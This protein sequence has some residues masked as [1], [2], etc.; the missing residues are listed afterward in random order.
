[1]ISES[2]RVT[3]AAEARFRIQ[4]PN[5]RPPLVKV[6]ALDT[7]AESVVR[8]LAAGGWQ[9]ATFF[10]AASAD[11]TLTDLTGGR[12]APDAEV[13]A[14]DLVILIAGPGGHAH[15]VSTIGNACSSRRVMTTGCVVSASSAS[16]RELA[17]TLAQLRPWSLMLVIAKS[18]E[19]LDDML[20]ALRA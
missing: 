19:Y 6:V 9:Q 5:S 12:R 2:A 1:M 11:G 13:E 20:T 8:R 10:V 7:I 17:K 15:G 14:A 18:D 16:E 3:S 4:A